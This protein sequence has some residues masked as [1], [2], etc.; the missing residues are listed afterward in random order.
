MSSERKATLTITG[1]APVEFPILTPTHG[2]ECVDIRALGGN[3]D[4]FGYDSGF[5]STASCKSSITYVDGAKGELLYRGYPIEQLT[6][7]CDFLEVAY[8]LKNGELPNVAQKLSF[9]ET[10]RKNTPVHGQMVNFYHGFRRDAHTMPVMVGVVG[11]LSA[12]HREAADFS[13]VEQRSLTIHRIIAKMPT[14]AAM[15]YKYTMG[16]PPVHPRNDLDYAANFVHMMFANPAEK[17]ELNPVLMRAFDRLLILHADH[18]QDAST[19]TVRMAGSSGANPFAC[20]SAAIACLSGREHGGAS[21]AC[22]AMLQEVGDVRKVA[23]MISRSRIESDHSKVTGFGLYVYR[24][25]DPRAKLMRRLCTE[26]LTELRLE[27]DPLFKL[28]IELDR[29]ALEDPYFVENKLYPNVDFYSG[30]LQKALGLPASMFGCI[31]AVARTAG[32]MAQWEEMRADPEY[33]IARPRQLYIGSA[34]R[35]VPA[36]S[37]RGS[38]RIPA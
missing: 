38:Q 2:N 12:F 13:D 19:S 20:I 18:A 27:N 10:I 21:E 14:L 29:I 17:F 5:E 23:A 25:F 7:R 8:L 4:R 3:T 1:E 36:P 26:V 37:A 35:D 6:E 16:H 22:L 28:A 33:K 32:W 11:A 9:A 30:I 34:R 31:V 15:A 24:N